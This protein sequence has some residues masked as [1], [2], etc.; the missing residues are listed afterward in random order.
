M[1]E[2]TEPPG[3]R[4]VRFVPDRRY[5]AAAGGAAVLAALVTL[6]AGDAP[7]RLLLGI[8]A[9]VLAGYAVGDLLYSPRVEA[10]P[11]GIVVRSP[12]TR[13]RLSWEQVDNVHAS[14][15]T[16]RGLRSTT[17]EIDAGEVLAVLSRRAIGV[18]PER[19]AEQIRAC[20]PPGR[21]VS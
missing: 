8:A 18:D 21:A 1:D 19:A 3:R 13:A 2:A 20:R 12:L 6:V 9:V 14:V 11:A 4:V 16:H 17:L 10:G 15:S 7:S 5:T